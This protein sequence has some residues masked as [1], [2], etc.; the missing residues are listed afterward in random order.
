[1]RHLATISAICL[2]CAGS[3]CAQDLGFKSYKSYEDYCFDNPHAPTCSDGKPLK[4]L[5]LKP[6]Y[7]VPPNLLPEGNRATV[8]TEKVHPAVKPLALAAD[9]RFAHPQPDLLVGMNVG[10]LLQSASVRQLLTQFA[11]QLQISPAKLDEMLR[12][13]GE[14]DQAW[15]S[16]HGG[17]SL[18]LLQG[19]TT[20][21]AGLVRMPDGKACYRI[22]STTVVI[23]KETSV[24]A[25]VQRL[26]NPAAAASEPARRMKELGAD[27]QLWLT[28]TKAGLAQAKFKS[29]NADV[30]AFSLG[31]RLRD[32]YHMEAILK[33][34][35]TAAARR[36]LASANEHSP[37]A[38]SAM[39]ITTALEGTSVRLTL[40]IEQAELS[41]VL[42]KALAGPA[43]QK[44]KALAAVANQPGTLTIHGASGSSQQLQSSGQIITVPTGSSTATGGITIQG[45]IQSSAKQG[46]PSR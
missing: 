26:K 20:F 33:T 29:A 8:R 25:A 13:A 16:L 27:N 38:D 3:L 15:M 42:D 28:G 23:G 39:K 14:V 21:P 7:K 45:G 36:L 17:D 22:S 34:A 11:G 31:M 9:W 35:S 40:R 18:L 5:D 10:A 1:M 2:L 6:A 41:R 37:L 32:G 44:L 12:Q 4:M 30:T 46:A 24:V 19:R 43:G